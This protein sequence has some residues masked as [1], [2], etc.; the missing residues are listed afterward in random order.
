MRET[1]LLRGKAGRCTEYQSHLYVKPFMSEGTYWAHQ[2]VPLY[3]CH[4]MEKID[5][6]N[7]ATFSDHGAPFLVPRPE[8]LRQASVVPFS[9]HV[10]KH[11]IYHL[12]VFV[13]YRDPDVSQDPEYPAQVFAI[14]SGVGAPPGESPHDARSDASHHPPGRPCC[15][16]GTIPGRMRNKSYSLLLHGCLLRLDLTECKIGGPGQ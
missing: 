11:R 13:A 14:W 15:T 6:G 12:P 4:Y 5:G 3:I 16:T 1:N 10:S 8:S 2:I 9:I 7:E